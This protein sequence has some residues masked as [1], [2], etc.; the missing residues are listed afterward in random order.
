MWCTA[1]CPAALP[2]WSGIRQPE[3]GP[4][5]TTWAGRD[6]TACT[7][8]AGP[9]G[10]SEKLTLT[11]RA[12]CNDCGVYVWSWDVA[13]VPDSSST[14]LASAADKGAEPLWPAPQASAKLTA[15]RSDVH[16][17]SFSHAGDAVAT[18]SRD[19]SV[20]VSYLKDECLL[21]LVSR[22]MLSLSGRGPKAAPRRQRGTGG[23]C[24]LS[25]AVGMLW[26]LAHAMAPRE[27]AC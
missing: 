23:A 6:Q 5:C 8:I 16:L 3:S 21:S 14:N 15:H 1:G 20:R 22:P 17:L 24:C 12:G 11:L 13:S 9:G 2:L 27:G 10:A 25:A 4:L 26:L 7:A 18:G 19:G